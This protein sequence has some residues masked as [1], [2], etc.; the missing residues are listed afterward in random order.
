LLRSLFEAAEERLRLGHKERG[1]TELVDARKRQLAEALQWTD[2]QIAQYGK[3]F[4]DSYWLA[5]PIETQVANARQVVGAD[6]AGDVIETPSVVC[7]E[8]AGTGATR[9]SLYTGDREG[10]FYRVCAAL[11]RVSANIIDARVHTTRD[12]KA[13]DNILVLDGQGKPY[14]DQRLKD[15]LVRCITDCLLSAELPDLPE[16]ERSR[17]GSSA[18]TVAASVGIADRA[19]SRTTVVEVNARDRRALLAGLARAIHECAHRVHSAHIATY[20]ERAVDVFYLTRADGK[21]LKSDE[22]E[23]LRTA[24]LAVAEDGRPRGT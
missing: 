22:V 13:L 10:L 24:L 12:G 2:T 9:V 1:R 8:D 15:R 23:Q 6:K 21:K 19:S 4:T 20:G 16:P 17:S 18:F 3:R 5:E 11:A 7:E 14:A